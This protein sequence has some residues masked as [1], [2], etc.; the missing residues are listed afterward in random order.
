MKIT[1][2]KVK[3]LVA[4]ITINLIEEDYIANVDNVINDYKKTVVIPGF[5]KGKTPIAIINK[6]Y[7]RPVMIEEVSK[8]LQNELYKYITE[9]KI[10]ILGS[11][12][13]L[14][15]DKIDWDS[16]KDFSFKYEIGLSPD[17]D[18]KITNKN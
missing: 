2:S 1:K 4:T 13:P 14:N 10:S 7:R 18:I 11:P 8:V 9:N 16:K 5:R 6:K 12:L 15:E 3:N 17:F